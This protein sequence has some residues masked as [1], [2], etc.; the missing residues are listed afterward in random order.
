VSDSFSLSNSLES[1]TSI[2]TMGI[3]LN[4]LVGDALIRQSEKAV[5]LVKRGVDD[6][7]FND[8]LLHGI[9]LSLVYDTPVLC[10]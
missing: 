3:K 6:R 10:L 7:I 2:E 1:L 4:G 9:A 5:R 8:N